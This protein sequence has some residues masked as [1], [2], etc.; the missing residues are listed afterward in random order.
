[1]RCRLCEREIENY[2]AQFNRLEI[3]EHHAVAICNACVQKFIQWQGKK[4]A[5]LFPTRAMKQRF[6]SGE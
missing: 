4:L 3:D 1:M 5:V 2:S 6:G